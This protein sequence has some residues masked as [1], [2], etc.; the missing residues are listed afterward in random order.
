MSERVVL[1]WVRD[2]LEY[3]IEHSSAK[4]QDRI[5]ENLPDIPSEIHLTDLCDGRIL[6]ALV[7]TVASVTYVPCGP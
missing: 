3:G 6:V 2:A 5:S 7:F 4:V 1:S